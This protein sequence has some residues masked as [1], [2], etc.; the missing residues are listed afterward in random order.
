ML[1][2]KYGLTVDAVE[3]VA[4]LKKIGIIN[5]D[6]EVSGIVCFLIIFPPNHLYEHRIA[7]HNNSLSHPQHLDN[8]AS[9]AR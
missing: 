7:S 5:V 8:N 6:L 4:T 1:G 9:K 3:S 2:H